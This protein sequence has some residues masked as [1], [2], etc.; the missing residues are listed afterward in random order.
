ME[1]SKRQTITPSLTVSNADAAITF[2]E[3]VFGA[4]VDGPVMHGPDGKAVVHAELLFGGMQIFLSD[5]FPAMGAYS[6]AHYGGTSVNLHLQVPDVD[7]TYADAVA[8]GATGKM[9]P[10]DAFWGE[11]YA[12]IVD[13]FGHGWGL[14]TPKEQL[15]N[16]QIQERSAQFWKQTA[17][18]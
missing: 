14:A 13:P 4:K 6:P 3:K 10:S 17:K 11:R 5:E 7:K 18:Q 15:T 1:N 2:Y 9:P 16:E 8:A 12:Y